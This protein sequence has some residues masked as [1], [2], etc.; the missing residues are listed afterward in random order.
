MNI[1]T[2]LNEWRSDSKID[3]TNLGKESADVPKLHH[4]Y[5]KMLFEAKMKL[6]KIQLAEKRKASVL[7]EYYMGDLNN[8][9]DLEELG[10]N[11]WPRKVLSKDVP[12]YL[13]KDNDMIKVKL[14]VYKVEECV[15]ALNSIL[16]EINRRGFHIKSAI[17]WERM[18]GGV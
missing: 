10:R 4:K 14:Q 9:E 1:D 3:I 18:I 2:I 13:D 5:L 8:E 15:E 12:R 6:K 17:D 16:N 11:P 7:F